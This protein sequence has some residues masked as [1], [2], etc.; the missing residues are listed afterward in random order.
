[1]SQIKENTTT[2]KKTLDNHQHI[3][4][5]LHDLL[6]I[7]RSAD[8]ELACDFLC[9]LLS[10]KE[11]LDIANRLALIKM[12]EQGIVQRAISKDLGVSLC[13]ITRGSF[14]LKRPNSP[15]KRG[16]GILKEAVKS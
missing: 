13:K 8:D 14:E 11:C 3:R 1:M 16:L 7:L 9:A 15:L 5:N 12:L 4:Q 10:K 6:K 2:L